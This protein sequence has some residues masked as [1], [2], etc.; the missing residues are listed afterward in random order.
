[1]TGVDV[2][3]VGA[4]MA[5]ASA[6][7]EIAA[8]RSVVLLERESQP[9]Y[10]AT[11]RSAALFSETYGNAV[12]RALSAASR[13]FY[14]QPPLGFASVP[15]LTPR[16]VV[17]VAHAGQMARLATWADAAHAIVA[18][19]RMLEPA[20]V[21][22]AVP[23]LRPE[24]VA[25][26]AAEPGA[27]D[28]DVDALQQGFLRGARARGATLVPGAELIGLDAGAGGWTVTTSAG[29]WQARVVVNAAG[30]WA[31]TVAVMAGARP[32]GVQ[33]MRR[34]ALT[35]DLPP[36]MDAAAWPMA[37]DTDE[38]FYFK[39][40]GGRL[41]L[42]PADETPM[43][44]C[45]VQPD[46]MDIAVCIDRIQQAANLPVRR[47]VRSWAG[48]RSFTADRTPV[49]GFDPAVPGLFW[50]AGQG[51]YGIQTAAAMGRLTAAL[52]AGEDVPQ[53]MQALGISAASLAPGRSGL[54]A[55]SPQ[56]T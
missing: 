53:E 46:E 12:I 26:G 7:Y 28:M 44:P 49:V 45:D 31:D 24:Y 10:H 38:A 35:V 17:M 29:T 32:C 2:V 47:V 25:G 50:L 34:T 41:L 15:L 56:T 30:A 51:G 22:A 13:M 39:P 8:T 20:E 16:G 33:P 48:L 23:L 54:R 19:V 42:S 36:G 43:P 37:I 3:V 9:G 4:G 40:E 11:G 55:V 27:M 5:G 18:S 6:A 1:M 14:Q 21:L 52:L